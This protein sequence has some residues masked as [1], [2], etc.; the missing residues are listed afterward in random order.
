MST[1]AYLPWAVVGVA[2]LWILA[3]LAKFLI[4]RPEPPRHAASH[5]DPF[6][7]TSNETPNP[8][9]REY[10]PPP[11]PIT[12]THTRPPFP[13]LADDNADPR[14]PGLGREDCWGSELT[15]DW[16]RHIKQLGDRDD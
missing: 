11:D 8:L 4:E 16:G 7:D 2:L 15:G 9:A 6:R 1:L 3:E 10:P 13:L 12:R 14:Y 5:H